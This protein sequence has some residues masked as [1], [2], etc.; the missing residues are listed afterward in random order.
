MTQAELHQLFAR[1]KK[2][3]MAGGKP[4]GVFAIKVAGGRQFKLLS[5]SSKEYKAQLRVDEALK[6][7]VAVAYD[8]RANLG[9]VWEDLCTFDQVPAA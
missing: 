5:V 7:C 9:D 4:F 3:V 6:H 1:I 8:G 2:R